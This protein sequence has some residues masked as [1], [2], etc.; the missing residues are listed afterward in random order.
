[1]TK[2]D[3][4]GNYC[5]ICIVTIYIIALLIGGLIFNINILTILF[6]YQE[7][8]A[9]LVLSQASKKDFSIIVE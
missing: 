5:D 7:T 3:Q 8:P 9:S 2:T 1:M 4:V 6:K